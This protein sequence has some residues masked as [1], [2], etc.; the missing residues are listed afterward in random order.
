[1]QEKVPRSRKYFL[2]CGTPKF[3]GFG[4]QYEHLNSAAD[5]LE[6]HTS[7]E[8]PIVVCRTGR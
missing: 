7:L 4:K 6:R 1:M 5:W 8:K 2:E 3:M